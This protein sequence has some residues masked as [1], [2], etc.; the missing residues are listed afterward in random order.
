LPL[1]GLIAVFAVTAFSQ[2]TLTAIDGRRIDVTGQDGKVVILAVGTSW[3]PLS[4]KQAEYANMLA[5]NY[6][7]KNVVVYFLMTD[8]TDAKSKNHASNETLAK[9]AT[10]NKLTMPILRDPD[11]GAT[12][13]KFGI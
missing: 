5:K 13:K 3:L 7:G 11:G 12:F 4:T 10:D 2:T 6:A 8:S 9:F 1:L